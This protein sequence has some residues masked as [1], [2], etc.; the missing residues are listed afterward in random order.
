VSVAALEPQPEPRAE[1][2]GP[3]QL[4][5]GR[6][7]LK[8]WREVLYIAA[9]YGVYSVIRDLRGNRPVSILQ[10]F[11]NAERVIDLEQYVGIFQE[12]RIQTWF[13]GTHWFIRAMDDFYGTAHFVIT[14]A[15]LLYLF[16][17]QSWRY[18]LW[19]NTLA[20][21]TALALIGFAFFPLMPPRLLPEHYH[22]VDT[23][24]S[25]GGFWSF[26]SGPVSAVSNQYAA[27]PSLHFA[28]SSWCALAIAPAVKR[29]WVKVIV[30]AYPLL[31]LLCIIVT[32]NHYILDAVGGGLCL[33]VGYGLSVAFAQFSQRRRAS[34]R[35][36]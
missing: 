33:A 16:F 15:A 13:L 4:Q 3:A 24:R 5:T 17:R 8:W 34:L 21:T 30:F 35:V 9:F 14:I 36:T 19:R 20:W 29:R 12:H 10:A 1:A 18:P 6:R 26:E 31:T 27:M 32:G 7:R 25:V 11:T 28:W 22:F 2:P 23:L